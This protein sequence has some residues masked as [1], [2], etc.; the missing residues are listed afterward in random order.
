MPE[1]IGINEDD[2]YIILWEKLPKKNECLFSVLVYCQKKPPT[3]LLADAPC[4]LE[5]TRHDMPVASSCQVE[6][7]RKPY[8]AIFHINDNVWLFQN[9][10]KPFHCLLLTTEGGFNS[11]ITITEPSV[12]RLPRGNLMKCSNAELTS[13]TCTN[14]SVLIRATADGKYQPLSAISW[15]IK[16]HDR[17]SSTHL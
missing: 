10:K 15:P 17:K 4:L 6:R 13:P 7:S 2:Q 16:K 1:A 14:R 12:I 9:D 5:L 3:V 8:T 11:I